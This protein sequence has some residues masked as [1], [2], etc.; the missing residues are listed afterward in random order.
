M[1]INE[2]DTSAVSIVKE[3]WNDAEF[4]AL[5]KTGGAFIRVWAFIRDST[6]CMQKGEQ[7]TFTTFGHRSD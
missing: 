1:V 4:Q 5:S 6:V 3:R 7:Y 2:K